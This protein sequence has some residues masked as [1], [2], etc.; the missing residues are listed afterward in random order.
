MGNMNRDEALKVVFE[1]FPKRA[2]PMH[3]GLFAEN[4]ADPAPFVTA[5]LEK[6][7]DSFELIQGKVYE[8]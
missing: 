3:Y 5:C 1:I 7:I 6:G 8:L 2:H 4:T